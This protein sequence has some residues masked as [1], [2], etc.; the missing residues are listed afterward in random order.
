MEKTIEQHVADI[1]TKFEDFQKMVDNGA[2]K[3]DL[4]GLTNELNE[5][6][7]QLSGKED[8]EGIT[9]KLDGLIAT[10]EEQGLAL[11]KMQEAQPVER[12]TLEEALTEKLK[13]F[14]GIATGRIV[15]LQIDKADIFPELY[16]TDVTRASVANHTLAY[17]LSGVGQLATQRNV[18]R[19]LFKSAAVGPNSNGIVRYVDQVARTN[20]ADWKAEAAQKPESAITWG[21]YSMEVEKIADT[22]PV[23]M[24]ALAD[25]DFIASEIRN[26]LLTNL[27]LKIDA[28]LWSGSG[29]TPI[30]WGIYTYAD[31]YTPVA[32][33][34]SNAT[35]Y[36]LLV[37]VQEDI[38]GSTKYMPNYAIMNIADV[39]EMRLAK[40]TA[41]NYIL[42]PFTSTDGTQVAGMTIVVSNSV[43]ANT[44][45]V[46]DFDYA[47]LYTLG[48]LSIDI[49]LIDKQF[50]ENMVTLRAEE[51]MGLLVRNVHTDA[52]RKVTD[53]DAAVTTIGS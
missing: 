41:G 12:K 24:E 7:G 33:G 49:G 44:M 14:E 3:E 5:I 4:E 34:I 9:A 15:K 29:A 45:V 27:E 39:N 31:T 53:I 48:S 26:L 18:L 11:L 23:T 19:S 38:A 32:A 16:K 17:R 2:K 13:D 21:E 28:D 36:D 30:I 8:A 52:F 42:P 10:A 20:N 43:T 47:T 37:K 1:N 6:K 50:I 51:R 35:I 25:V 22:I 40:D 46:G